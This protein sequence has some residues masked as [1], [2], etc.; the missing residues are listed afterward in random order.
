MVVLANAL[1]LSR[2]DGLV[3]GKRVALDRDE[4]AVSG[5]AVADSDRNDIA[6]HEKLGLDAR[7]LAIVADDAGECGR[8]LLEGGNGLLG[9]ALL[10]DTNDGVENED[11][12]DLRV[13]EILVLVE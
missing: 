12:E 3:D 1:A 13:G 8:V 9:A 7:D 10:R 6:G 5:D 2:Q 4:A 11:G